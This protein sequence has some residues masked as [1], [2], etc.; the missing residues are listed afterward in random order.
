M[1]PEEFRSG[2]WDFAVFVVL[3]THSRCIVVEQ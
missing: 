1:Y 2:S 3:D